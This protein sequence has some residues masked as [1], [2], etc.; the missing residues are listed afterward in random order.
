MTTENEYKKLIW[1]SIIHSHSVYS[2]EYNKFCDYITYLSCGTLSL[3]VSFQKNYIPSHPQG[4]FLLQMSLTLLVLSVVL[5]IL[6]RFG[7]AQTPLDASKENLEKMI[8]Q[9][10]EDLYWALKRNPVFHERK[11]FSHA[12]KA[13]I[14]SFLLSL[15]L[16]T[17]FVML[18]IDAKNT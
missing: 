15:V 5:G 14:F 12:R 4:I 9:K 1:E 8:I 10:P 3:L 17:W 13:L 2:D 18:N 6:V 11:I 7:I 16:L